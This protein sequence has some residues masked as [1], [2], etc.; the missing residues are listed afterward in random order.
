M[1]KLVSIIVILLSA[2]IAYGKDYQS[3]FSR[4]EELYKQ[5][6]YQK[7]IDIYDEIYR[8]GY[9]SAGLF[10]N[11][12][13]S[14]Y[15]KGELGLSRAYFIIAGMYEPRNRDIEYNTDIIESRLK[16]RFDQ[17]YSFFIYDFYEKIVKSFTFSTW[18]IVFYSVIS[19]F[20]LLFIIYFIFFNLRLKSIFLIM[21]SLMMTAL[22]IF[23]FYRSSYKLYNN[24]SIGVVIS[25]QT[26]VRNGPDPGMVS[27]AMINDGTM[28]RVS[29][30]RGDYLRITLPNGIVGWVKTENIFH[31]TSKYLQ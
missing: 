28:V 27:L 4:A 26:N 19:L 29:E 9:R 11:I 7:A 24:P 1:K 20:M 31:I 10:Y 12:G 8:E 13:C 22:I 18:N 21:L 14:Y 30:K 17:R 15:K 6:D 23:P 3:M 2:A 16:D 5:G 25:D